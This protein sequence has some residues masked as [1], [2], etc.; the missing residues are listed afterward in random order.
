MGSC[1]R[2]RN[3]ELSRYVRVIHVFVSTSIERKGGKY[4]YSIILGQ[5]RLDYFKF[6]FNENELL[7]WLGNYNIRDNVWFRDYWWLEVVNSPVRLASC[8]YHSTIDRNVFWC[9]AS[10]IPSY[11]PPLLIRRKSRGLLSIDLPINLPY[12]SIQAQWQRMEIPPTP[13]QNEIETS[14]KPHT[15]WWCMCALTSCAFSTNGL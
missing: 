7:S 4:G 6:S 3:P 8:G 10:C 15:T 11:D 1:D 14:L 13:S 2:F 12:T 5:W 9:L